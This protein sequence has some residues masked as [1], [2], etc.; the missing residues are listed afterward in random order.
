MLSSVRSSKI[1]SSTITINSS[2]RIFRVVNQRLVKSYI[3]LDTDLNKYCKWAVLSF[4]KLKD[5]LEKETCDVL[6][7]YVLVN[8]LV[9]HFLFFFF[10]QYFLELLQPT[11]SEKLKQNMFI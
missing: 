11:C 2:T 7:F 4:S 1:H 5:S 3:I 8:I 9:S 10:A 6:A